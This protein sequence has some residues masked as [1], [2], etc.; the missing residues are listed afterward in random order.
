MNDKYIFDLY[1]EKFPEILNKILLKK[2]LNDEFK[3]LYHVTKESSVKSILKNGLLTN[4]YGNIHGKMEI[5]PPEKT[6][7]LSKNKKSG[8]LNSNLFI[9]DERLVVLE[10]DTKFI[11]ENLIYPDDG[12]WCGFADE[13]FLVDEFEV[14]SFFDIGIEESKNFLKYISSLNNKDLVNFTKPLWSFY[15]KKEGE[16][17]IS[18]DV[19]QSNI[20]K[21]YD[22]NSDSLLIYN[23][24]KSKNKI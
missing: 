17:S 18:Q 8:N 21:I 13:N 6:I 19:H 15:L 3:Y 1:A 10:I 24:N 7:Y 5:S 16:I 22:Y 2:S 20:I 12:F 9:N 14:K 11:N 23:K 4:F